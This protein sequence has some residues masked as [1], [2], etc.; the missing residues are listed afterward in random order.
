M[1]L[2]SELKFYLKTHLKPPSIDFVWSDEDNKNLFEYLNKN[3]EE[4]CLQDQ[5]NQLKIKQAFKEYFEPVGYILFKMNGTQ[6]RIKV[7]P[8][9]IEPK[10]SVNLPAVLD[11]LESNEKLIEYDYKGKE[12]QVSIPKE[13]KDKIYDFINNITN[14]EVSRK[15]LARYAVTKF[16][17]LREHDIVIVKEDHIF[18][19]TLGDSYKRNVKEE[20]KNTAANRYNGID[21]DELKSLYEEFF[22]QQENK[23]FFYYVAKL[24]TQ[25]YF[26]EQKMDNFTY[27]AKRFSLIQSIVSEQLNNSYN[28]DD[29]F[30]T[31]FAGYIFRIHFQEVFEHIANFILAEI[32]ISNDYMLNFVKYYSSDVIVLDGKRYKVPMLETESGL[33]WNVASILSIVKIYVKTKTSIDSMKKNI[34]ELNKRLQ[35]LHVE[36]YPPAEYKSILLNKK[37]KLEEDIIQDKKKIEKCYDLL[38]L[39]KDKDEKVKLQEEV[40]SIR[41][42][43][44]KKREERK[45]IS[46]KMVK[47][48]IINEYSKIQNDIDGITRQIRRSQRV[49]EQNEE[50]YTS[51]KH[52]LA[53]AL[54]SKRVLIG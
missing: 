37:E 20:E 15:E 5:Q 42:G 41:D 30:C 27:E 17:E 49:L 12:N 46:S 24:F 2:N 21:E 48:S 29:D 51:I 4:E 54:A 6:L 31:G 9:K 33:R 43:I 3:C 38:D 10:D 11:I 25:I 32:A 34:N 16:F 47:A 28:N 35:E 7:F 53:K 26:L 19:K 23:N 18:I 50:A 39:T 40:R 14:E 13:L 1:M 22:A 8:Y 45:T 36:G 44:E 52:A